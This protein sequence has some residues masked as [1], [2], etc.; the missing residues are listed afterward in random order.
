MKKWSAPGTTVRSHPRS[1]A[2]RR[3]SGVEPYA[4][5]SPWIQ[6]TR[7]SARDAGRQT[8]LLER[9]PD[10]EE[11]VGEKPARR[12]KGA[13][14]AE[15]E[16]GEDERPARCRSR[17]HP[18]AATRSS[19][20]PGSSVV[21]PGGRPD[22]P[23]VEPQRGEA[24][25][26]GEEPGGPVDDLRV[27]RP[28]E[29]R[30]RVRDDRRPGRPRREPEKPFQR[31]RGP[32]YR[33]RDEPG[34]SRSEIHVPTLAARPRSEGLLLGDEA[35]LAVQAP[36]L[37]PHPARQAGRQEGRRRDLSAQKAP[38]EP[39]ERLGERCVLREAFEARHTLAERRQ[40]ARLAGKVPADDDRQ[41]ARGTARGGRAG[42]SPGSPPT[43]SRPGARSPPKRATRAP[44]G[45][46]SSSSG[47]RSKTTSRKTA[48][49]PPDSRAARASA[50]LS[51]RRMRTGRASRPRGARTPSTYSRPS[52]T[53]RTVAGV[54]APPPRRR[55]PPRR[56]S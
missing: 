11:D 48:P 47:A 55:T 8:E 51:A 29:L 10:Q 45:P 39:L 19:V 9:N 32:R 24:E 26:A 17:I 54:T 49:T 12:V 41:P 7:H 31:A 42:K 2:T 5:S 37:L 15:R 43:A 52:S 44:R 53:T 1:A 27:H 22:A 30:M 35:E 20:S 50:R 16:T 46:A 23:E 6:K 18:A 14:R 28:A 21:A 34:G 40:P 3:A 13:D 33:H 36:A 38:E 4:S 56:P 25:G